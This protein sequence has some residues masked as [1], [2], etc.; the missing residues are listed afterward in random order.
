MEVPRLGVQS[1]LSCQPTTA[2]AMQDLICFCNLPHSSW[3]R[4]IP[5]LLSE[6][7]DQTCVSMDISQIHFHCGTK[8]T[9]KVLWKYLSEHMMPPFGPPEDL[10]E[11]FWHRK[12]LAFAPRYFSHVCMLDYRS[13][14]WCER[15]ASTG[16]QNLGQG[17]ML[18][19]CCLL[20]PLSSASRHAST[21]SHSLFLSLISHIPFFSLFSFRHSFFF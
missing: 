15:D 20:P 13:Q 1:E 18:A 2:T 19:C 12:T 8:R 17:R 4:Q 3:Q 7:G 6:A 9:P 11:I 16:R 10:K 14:R 21:F 5:N